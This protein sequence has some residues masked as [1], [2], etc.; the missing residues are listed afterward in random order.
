M[1]RRPP[2]STLFPYTTLF[3]STAVGMQARQY[4]YSV[5]EVSI[6]VGTLVKSL[7]VVGCPPILHVAIGVILTTL[8][9]ETVGHFMANHYTDS[10]IVERIVGLG[11]KERILKNA[12]REAYLIGCRVIISINRLRSHEPFVLVN[13]LSGS[14]FYDFVDLELT[15]SLYILVE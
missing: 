4:L 11:V 10:A 14:L 13:G 8:V 2:R 12:R 3:R 7:G 9:I 15:T 1:I 6:H 5:K